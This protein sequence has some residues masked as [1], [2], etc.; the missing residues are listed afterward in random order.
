MLLKLKMSYPSLRKILYLALGTAVLAQLLLFPAFSQQYSP[1]FSLIATEL[2]VLWLVVFFVRR[3]AAPAEALLL[4]NATPWRALLLTVPLAISASLLISQF[5]LYWGRFLGTLGHSLP[6]HIQRNIIEVQL[7]GDLPAL[8][9]GLLAVVL[10][11]SV[12]EELL[13]RGLVFA[14]LYVHRGPRVAVVGAGFFFALVHFNPWQLPALI[15]LGVLLGM[16]VYWTHSV[17]PAMLA[18]LLNNALS[19]AG[20]NLKVYWGIEA[21]SAERLYSLPVLGLLLLV[22]AASALR[23]QRLQAT[24]PLPP[25]TPSASPAVT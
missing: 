14:G 2:S 4:L 12:A 24:M 10:S 11:P 9:F 13:F 23:L 6:L 3:Q 22:F 16:L 21:L 5:D 20:L 1:Q 25:R 19:F 7:A 18:H 17:Y 8:L 15:F